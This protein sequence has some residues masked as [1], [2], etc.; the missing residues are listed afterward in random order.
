MG[1]R[2]DH[3]FNTERINH[4]YQDPHIESSNFVLHYGDLTDSTNLIRIIKQVPA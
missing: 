4:I 2:E 3:S 1:S